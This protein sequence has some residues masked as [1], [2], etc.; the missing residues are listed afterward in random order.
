MSGNRSPQRGAITRMDNRTRGVPR[1]IPNPY[2]IPPEDIPPDKA[3]VW[4]RY[5]L[6]GQEDNTN[7]ANWE[8]GGWRPVPPERHP[9]IMGSNYT[10]DVIIV[11]GLILMENDRDVAEDWKNIYIEDAS[12]MMNDQLEKARMDNYQVRYKKDERGQQIPDDEI[13]F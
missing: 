1:R 12:R 11:G 13:N 3:Y 10:K 8:K 2:E 5:N 4:V 9:Y 7:Y 6:M